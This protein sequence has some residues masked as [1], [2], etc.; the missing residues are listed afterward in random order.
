MPD[1]S[2]ASSSERSEAPQEGQKFL[3]RA[4]RI[5]GGTWNEHFWQE[6]MMDEPLSYYTNHNANDMKKLIKLSMALQS[7]GINS[8][9]TDKLLCLAA[10]SSGQNV[11]VFSGIVKMLPANAPLDIQNN[12]LPRHP[13]LLPIAAEKLHITLLHQTIAKPLKGRELPQYD[14]AITFGDCYIAKRG[15]L[16]SAF[17]VVNEQD[18]LRA[19]VDSFGV[20]IEPTRVY[21]ISLANLTGKTSE[22]VGH[23]EDMPIRLEECELI[24]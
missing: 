4:N 18:E 11:T 22:S 3:T 2:E 14:G 1:I 20:G 5:F 23:T 21:H 13:E 24:G 17:V 19:Y 10:E 7:R 6:I 8:A 15:D 9:V 16:V 12:I